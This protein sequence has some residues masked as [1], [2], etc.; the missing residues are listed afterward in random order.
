MDAASAVTVRSEQNSRGKCKRRCPG[1]KGNKQTA[2]KDKKWG[3]MGI[4]LKRTVKRN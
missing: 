3:E 1:K 2:A 4:N